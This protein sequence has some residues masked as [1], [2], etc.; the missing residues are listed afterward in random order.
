MRTSN[1]TLRRGAVLGL[2]LASLLAAALPPAATGAQP[3]G[4]LVDRSA[5]RVCA[6]PSDLP[7]SNEAGE[8]F[9]NKI[10]ELMARRL[11]VSVEYTWYPQSVGFVR[12]TLRAHRCDLIMGVVAADELVQ[13]TNP[14]YRSTYVMLVR[15][16][17][18]ERLAGLGSP[19]IATARF[20]V[21]AGT[22]PADL[23]A[24]R[25]LIGRVQPYN[26]VVDT[27]VEKPAR[28][29]LDDLVAGVT[30]VGMLWGPIA[31]YWIKKEGLP[32]VMTPLESDMRSNLRLDFRISMGV[33]QEDQEWKRELNRLIRELRPEID[34]ILLDYGVPLLDEQGRLIT[35]AADAGVSEPA[36]YRTAEY[37][38]PVPATL[39]GATVLDTAGLRR[40]IE[41][42]RPVLV[43]VLPKPRPPADRG[44]GRPWIEPKR[45][46]IPGS[47]WLPNVGYGELGPDYRG[48]FERSLAELTGGDKTRPIVF[49]CDTNCW[50]S[51]NA[52]K[53]A[54]T[55]LG[56]AQVHWYPDGVEGWRKAGFELTPAREI[57]Q[58][59]F[60]H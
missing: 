32:L 7:Y 4:E 35:A 50:M 52:A 31:G 8:G 47:V 46:D 5:L 36:G 1:R 27:R 38:A 6:D 21:I 17:D 53:R 43:D 13:N 45:D 55:E 23:L 24:R 11:G 15:E 30:D 39:A 60:D 3:T 9:E 20:G 14:Y 57:P 51:W 28:Q 48:Y 41:E 25:G 56:Y 33:R 49:Y 34:R 26:L 42:R 44:P 2:G 29:L 22:P 18:K 58:P 10:A 59:G 12:N 37:R 19:D 54:V 40:L 16:E